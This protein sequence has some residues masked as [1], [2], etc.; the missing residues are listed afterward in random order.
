[1]SKSV[2]CTASVA[3]AEIIIHR[4]QA[5][6][7]A[8]SDISVLMADKQE[9]REFAHEHHTRAPE[10]AVAGIGTGLAVGGVVGWLAGVG[11]LALPGL[12]ALIAAG[13]IMGALS[14]AAVAGTVGGVTGALIGM[15]IPEHEAKK[16]EGR[17]QQ[18]NTLVSVHS[19]SIEEIRRAR[20]VFA[21]AGA[22]DI[23]MAD[24]TTGTVRSLPR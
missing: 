1:M 15:G 3:K 13:P 19:E 5:A 23:A 22:E 24:K 9:T 16:Y 14:G 4:L 21:D 10:G 8:D 6:G 2:F 17:V 7:F 20:D 12:G 11:S 18:G